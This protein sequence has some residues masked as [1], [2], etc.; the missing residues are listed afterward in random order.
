MSTID[1]VWTG[2]FDDG[3]ELLV[4]SWFDAAGKEVLEA[5]VRRPGER[6][7][8]PPIQLRQAP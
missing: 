2:R 6:C 4:S 1:R 7:W 5:A 8:G 3:S